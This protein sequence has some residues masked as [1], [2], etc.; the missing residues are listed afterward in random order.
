ML[1]IQLEDQEQVN[2]I[3]PDHEL[4][5]HLCVVYNVDL[6]TTES[7]ISDMNQHSKAGAKRQQLP[8]VGN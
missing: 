2:A 5:C 3:H 8:S 1:Q 6:G 4:G 7:G